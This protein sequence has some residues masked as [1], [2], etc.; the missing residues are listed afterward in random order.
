M[1]S[2]L[3]SQLDDDKDGGVDPTEAAGFLREELRYGSGSPDRSNRFSRNDQ[4]VSVTELWQ[5]WKTSSVY[6]W[7]T[8]DVINWLETHVELPHLKEVFIRQKVRGVAPLDKSSLFY[9]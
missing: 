5:R 8:D 2:E 1:I 4:H 9:Y 7:T 3:H 6:N